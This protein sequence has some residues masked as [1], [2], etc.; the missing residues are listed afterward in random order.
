MLTIQGIRR[1]G[2]IDT[3]IPESEVD[4]AFWT[5]REYNDKT[6]KWYYYFEYA[7]RSTV[8]YPLITFEY[9]IPRKGVFSNPLSQD[10]LLHGELDK[11]VY[12][13]EATLEAAG[14]INV[15]MEPYVN[16]YTRER[17]P[18]SATAQPEHSL[19]NVA[20]PL[21]SEFSSSSPR[22]QTSREER[23]PSWSSLSEQLEPSNRPTRR[24][25]NANAKAGLAESS[26]PLAENAQN[27]VKRDIL[28][29]SDAIIPQKKSRLLSEPADTEMARDSAV[30]AQ[31][32][33]SAPITTSMRKG[34][35][36]AFNQKYQRQSRVASNPD[37]RAGTIREPPSLSRRDN[38][39]R[40]DSESTYTTVEPESDEI[41]FTRL[42]G[43]GIDPPCSTCESGACIFDPELDG[44]RCRACRS[45]P[46]A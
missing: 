15:A 34:Y 23:Q 25:I 11:N 3:E 6:Q 8:D 21:Q 27:T 19:T 18:G 31:L 41:P 26:S 22:A 32:A 39:N 43:P 12:V 29:G 42:R 38:T 20:T 35:K 17:L 4:D 44:F 36:S 30:H 14:T 2:R 1:L 16:R 46:Y 7:V 10:P 13:R 40:A 37:V 24:T 5:N 33:I 45:I 9:I 28:N